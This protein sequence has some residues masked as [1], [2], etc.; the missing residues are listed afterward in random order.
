MVRGAVAGEHWG[1]LLR[2]A[3]GVGAAEC[4]WH[5]AETAGKSS[6]LHVDNIRLYRAAP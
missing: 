5:S 6:A 3:V 2:G 4:D 1:L